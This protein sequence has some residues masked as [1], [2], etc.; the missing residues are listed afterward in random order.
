MPSS[1][2]SDPRWLLAKRIAESPSFHKSA[3]LRDFLLYVAEKGLTGKPEEITE[4]L[5]GVRVFGREPGYSPAEDNLVRV[6]ARSLRT[7][8]KE[9]FDSDGARETFTLEIPKG[10]Y[11]PEFRPRDGA[12]AP[13]AGVGRSDRET[14]WK[15]A[16]AI[17][18]LMAL[19]FGGLWLD[20]RFGAVA[21]TR[22]PIGEV[23]SASELSVQLVM[24]DSAQVQINNLLGRPMT[25]DEYLDRKSIDRI[26]ATLQTPAERRLLRALASRQITSWADVRLLD[27]LK[28]FDRELFGRWRVRH[29]RHMQV[30][31]FKS[32]NFVILATPSSNPWASLFEGQL[33]FQSSNGW[34]S[35]GQAVPRI[36]NREPRSGEQAEYLQ[37]GDN[38]GT[39]STPVRVAVLPNLSG[40][41]KV[42]L[43]AGLSMEGTEAGVEYLSDPKNLQEIRQTLGLEYLGKAKG[44][45]LLLEASSLQGSSKGLRVVS[46]RVRR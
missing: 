6:S 3:R 39:H 28:T 16:A 26:E 7:K 18:T 44:W 1:L 34:D 32:D 23:F 27:R 24:T 41:G 13:D 30:R 9:Y 35:Q 29:A 14:L 11:V 42:M 4:Q 38:N 2:E 15:W 37:E 25:L 8:L 22:T 17:S 40:N 33:N 46:S 36:V 10:S 5:I 45:E 43:I 21:Q 12:A 19:A 31:D 20:E